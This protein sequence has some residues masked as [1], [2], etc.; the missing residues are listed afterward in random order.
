M[1]PAAPIWTGQEMRGK[2]PDAPCRSVP[3]LP[4]D[5]LD[6]AVGGERGDHGLDVAGVHA[7]DIPCQRVANRLTIFQAYGC[8]C[9]RR[10]LVSG[11]DL[12]STPA[13][14]RPIAGAHARLLV[15]W[16]EVVRWVLG[17]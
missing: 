11:P 12:R 15:A 17:C 3:A 9:H 14:Q 6:H 10:P 4:G 8:I 7:P 1:L 5:V 13:G 16:N 2:T